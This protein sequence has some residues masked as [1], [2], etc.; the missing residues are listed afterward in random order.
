MSVYMVRSPYQFPSKGAVAACLTGVH[1]DVNV[2]AVQQYRAL[3]VGGH[4]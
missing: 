4:V 1:D 3:L 2:I